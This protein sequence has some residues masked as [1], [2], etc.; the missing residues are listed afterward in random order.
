M[1]SLNIVVLDEEKFEKWLRET[2]VEFKKVDGEY[3]LGRKVSGVE[4]MRHGASVMEA[5]AKGGKFDTVDANM[6]S[7]MEFKM[8]HLVKFVNMVKGVP[9]VKLCVHIGDYS[10][11]IQH[12]LV[13][14]SLKYSSSWKTVDLLKEVKQELYDVFGYSYLE[15]L[16]RGDKIKPEDEVKLVTMAGS[17]M[18]LLEFVEGMINASK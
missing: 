15:W 7:D 10:L 18:I 17:A 2:G 11:E 12:R 3:K 6:L 9:A 4:A 1:K 16:K 13:M 8:C 14:G 5:G